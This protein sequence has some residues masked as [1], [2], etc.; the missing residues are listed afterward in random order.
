MK[1]NLAAGLLTVLVVEMHGAPPADACG[2]KL[3]V[4]SQ[5]PR[6]AIART[7][8]PSDVLLLG[9]PPRR[10]ELDLTAA[11]HRV[12]VAPNAAAAKK[13]PYAVVIADSNL[14]GEARS[15]FGGAAV[16]VRSGDVSAD[17]RSVEKEVAR[18]PVRA[19]ESR[20]VVAARRT[21]TPIAAGPQQDPNRRIMAARDVQPAAEPTPVPATAPTPPEKAATPAPRPPEKVATVP[22]PAPEV[23]PAPEPKPRAVA[24][25]NVLPSEVYFG[26]NSSKIGGRSIA[27]AARWLKDNADVQVVIEGHADPTGNPD[28]N[29]ALAQRRAEYVRD[30]LVSAGIDQS[31]L[32]VVSYGDTRLKYGRTDSRNRRVVIVAK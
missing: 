6:R 29:L 27:R 22:R 2:V 17:V 20:A 1:W 12:E 8:N 9:S 31:R 16:V 15:R 7:S 14:Q 18:K 30:Q 3:T 19:D 26:L 10:L 25:A 5:A 32:E 28:A 23:A 11:G 21:R 24:R 4:K 13:K